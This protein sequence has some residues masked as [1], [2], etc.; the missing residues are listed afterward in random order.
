V[1]IKGADFLPTVSV[2][3]EGL[4]AASV[5]WLSPETV[6]VITPPGI[7]GIAN[8]RVINGD[9]IPVTVHS[10]FTY[11]G[12]SAP[13][14]RVETL[15][16]DRGDHRGGTFVTVLGQGFLAEPTVLVGD[17]PLTGVRV[18]SSCQLTGVT[19]G[20][21]P[22]LATLML[23]NRDGQSTT[24]LGAYA[25]LDPQAAA[26]VLQFVS[27]VSGSTIGGTPVTV[28]GSHFQPGARVFFESVSLTDW[29]FISAQE[30]TGPSPAGQAGPARLRVVNPDGQSSVPVLGFT[31]LEP[32]REPR[33]SRLTWSEQALIF[34]VEQLVP[35]THYV[36]E[37][38]DTLGPGAWTV[39][40]E[41]HATTSS[42][43]VTDPMPLA[44]SSSFYRVRQSD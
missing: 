6:R 34:V 13:P 8:L 43:T 15:Q 24:K 11:E 16:P 10:G 1:E 31:Y 12:E 42:I 37:R 23:R 44:R 41:F 21:A 40:Q 25:Y 18:L 29:E 22:G 35:D 36:L 19:P 14:P 27:P 33:F 7:P 38:V 26:P 39:R 9:A 4:V 2:D 32:D 5:Q 20:G 3:F 28:T 17:R 30:L